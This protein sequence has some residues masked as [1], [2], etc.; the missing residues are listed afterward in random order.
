M[1]NIF[2]RGR[3]GGVE[4]LKVSQ[5]SAGQFAR[6]FLPGYFH[7]RLAALVIPESISAGVP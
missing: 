1:V 2:K 7:S 4:I 5:I 6:Q 3:G